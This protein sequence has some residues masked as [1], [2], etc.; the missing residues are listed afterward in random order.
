MSGHHE[1]RNKTGDKKEKIIGP[2][3]VGMLLL[4]LWTGEEL[5]RKKDWL[6]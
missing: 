5:S 2:E 3:S 1:E 4:G 6:L